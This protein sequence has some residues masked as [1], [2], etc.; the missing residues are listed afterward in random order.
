[1][2]RLA[3]IDYALMVAYFAVVLGAAIAAFARKDL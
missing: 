1:M 3:W 2:I